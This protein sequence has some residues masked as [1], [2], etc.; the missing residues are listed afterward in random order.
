MGFVEPVAEIDGENCENSTEDVPTCPEIADVFSS[1]VNEH[2]T[3]AVGND[4]E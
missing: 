2:T 3:A 1:A 4:D